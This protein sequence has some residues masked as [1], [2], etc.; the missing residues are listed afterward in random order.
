MLSWILGGGLALTADVRSVYL[1][2]RRSRCYMSK[3][4][5]SLPTW[6][7]SA[8]GRPAWKK[9]LERRV[10]GCTRRARKWAQKQNVKRKLPTR[11][12]WRTAIST[13]L[14]R[15]RGFAQYSQLALS[16]APP[17]KETDWNWP[18]IDHLKDAGTAEVAVETRLVNDMKTIM[19]EK[20]FSQMIAH[21]AETL[22]V[23]VELLPI[24]WSCDRS[25]AVRQKVDEPPIAVKKTHPGR[26]KPDQVR[27]PNSAGRQLR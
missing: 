20:E 26:T 18:S 2:S 14:E 22:A 25:F 27:R 17:L 7:D 3:S 19:T 6:T 5:L 4:G 10:Q 21:L 24:D 13:A 23:R 15:C 9:W 8:G 11:T 12:E 16:V 1:L